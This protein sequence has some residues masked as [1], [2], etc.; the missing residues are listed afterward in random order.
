MRWDER[1]LLRH[2]PLACG[3]VAAILAVGSAIST[4]VGA[5]VLGIRLSLFA[6][7]VGLIGVI[8]NRRVA[9]VAR[10]RHLDPIQRAGLLADLRVTP[11]LPITVSAPRSDP[12]GQAFA[13]ELLTVLREADW[14]ARGVRLNDTPGNANSGLV[15]AISAHG[16]GIPGN[17]ARRLFEALQRVGLDPV[18]GTA[19]RLAYATHLELSVGRRPG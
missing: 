3:I 6:A 16:D 5:T 1:D 2:G 15:V 17:E 18:T 9:T 12:E 19:A 4:G 7:V 14:P 8:L 11:S 13:Q 10:L